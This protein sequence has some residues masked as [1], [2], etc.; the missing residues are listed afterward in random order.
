MMK[1]KTNK[2]IAG[3]AA[4]LLLSTAMLGTSTYAW[5][6]MNKEVKV[7]GMQVKA[8]A[9][10]GL[11]INEVADYDSDTWDELATGGWTTAISLR[12][13][14]TSDLTTWWHANS[15]KVTNE[16]GA[17]GTAV[18]T[19]NTV[20]ISS[21]TYYTNITSYD[22][23]P[24]KAAAD[25]TDAETIVLYNDAHFGTDTQYDDG[26]GYYVMYKYYLKSSKNETGTYGIA[27]DLL[28]ANVTATKQNSDNS[29]TTNTMDL[30]KA[31]RVGVKIDN[32]FKIFAPLYNTN[33]TYKVASDV[34][35]IGSDDVTAYK[36]GDYVGLAAVADSVTFAIPNTLTNG[37]EVDVYV[38]FE[39]E[40]PNCKS[41][42]LAAVLD[43]Y[44][45]DISFKDA[46]L[47]NY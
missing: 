2:K 41:E 13:T 23:E 1:M 17:S 27:G 33:Q 16:A 36:G 3:A 35:A 37:K 10:E 20:E 26:E 14:S 46:S 34:D 24:L 38:W 31:L 45:I 4:M 40:D 12:P 30:D 44:Q 11:L 29:G 39:G 42:N 28:Q 47:N 32:S 6:T 7:T 25:G 5:F 15:K 8:H 43:T 9:E 19:V 21:G 18:D 22:K